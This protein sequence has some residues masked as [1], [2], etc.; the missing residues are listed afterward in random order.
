M[1][2]RTEDVG[3]SHT[4]QSRHR[5]TASF[6]QTASVIFLVV[7]NFECLRHVQ[8]KQRIHKHQNWWADKSSKCKINFK[9]A[10]V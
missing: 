1:S 8:M 7:S 3:Q 2:A 10:L 4:T 6:N 9:L 5:C